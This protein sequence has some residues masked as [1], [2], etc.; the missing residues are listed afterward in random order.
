MTGQPLISLV[1]GS[2]IPQIGL[3]V[4]QTPDD[5]AV[6]VVSAAIEAGYRHVDTA[7]IYRNE[8][9]VGEGLRASGVARDEIHVTTKLWNDDQG[10]DSAL[11]AC[12]ESLGR[13]G[14]DKIDLYLIHWPSPH[15]GLYV[16]SWKAL[17]R[18]KEEGRV[19]AIGVSN[20][21]AEHLDRIIDATGVT[22]ALNQI[23]LHPD[24]QQRAL[25]SL[26]DDLGIRTESWSPLG[27][28]KLLAD[29]VIA[30]IAAKHGRTPAQTIIRW[31]ID[32]GL[33]VIPKS[34]TPS[35]IVENFDVFGFA[36]DA[37]DLAAIDALDGAGNRIGP[38]PLTAAF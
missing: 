10:Y 28:G 29:P 34:V 16:D 38:D 33:I 2:T 36:L 9:G 7:A 13:L 22:P 15:R 11:K 24:F 6:A 1:D 27:Q 12:D 21:A 25:R 31:H 5:V 3:G 32:Q 4:W 26:H 20:F 14:I 8:Q 23:E 30:R 18:L 37:E 17:V 35:R 19:G